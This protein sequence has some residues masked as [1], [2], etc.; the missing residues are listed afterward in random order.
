[1]SVVS[2][3]G[4]FP[5][6]RYDDLPWVSAR[7][8]ES[9][10]QGGTYTTTE[11]FTLDP[12]DQDPANPQPRSFTTELGTA[13]LWYRF[14]WVDE[15]GDETD[16]TT[17][18]QNTTGVVPGSV[19]A[20]ATA[21]ELAT[22]IHVNATSKADA[23]NRVLAA[24]AGEIVAE[25]GRNDFSGWELELVEQVNLARAQELWD[26]MDKPWGIMGADSEFGTTRLARDTFGRHAITLAPLKR[27]WGIA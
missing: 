21:A 22:I 7:L 9:A 8:E 14:V 4:Y 20:F 10:T 13:D 27:S 18:A 5:P 2:F 17:P 25:T 11:T 26:Q 3:P 1:M 15:S 23:L 16:P 19:T 24:A 6:P 12:V